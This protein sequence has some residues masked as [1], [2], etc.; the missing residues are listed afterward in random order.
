MVETAMHRPLRVFLVSGCA[1][2]LFATPLGAAEPSVAETD[3][4]AQQASIPFANR[5]GIRDWVV[6]DDSNLLLQDRG[7]QWYR[8]RL[9][10]PSTYLAFTSSLRFATGPS[11]TLET[12][13][14]VIVRGQKF[15]IVSLTRIDPPS[16]KKK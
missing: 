12:L 11:G 8:A 5:G 7:G 16:P 4:P 1:L 10:A 14:S 3:A 9:L 15:P 2:W 6:E 13:D